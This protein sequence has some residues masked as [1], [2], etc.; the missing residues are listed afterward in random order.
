MSYARQERSCTYTDGQ[1]GKAGTRA[2]VKSSLKVECHPQK[3]EA[4]FVSSLG[5]NLENPKI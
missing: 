3:Q 5:K 4:K 2:G 1:G